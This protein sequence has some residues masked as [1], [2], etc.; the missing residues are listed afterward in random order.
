MQENELLAV[1]QSVLFFPQ[2]FCYS[3]IMNV[4]SSNRLGKEGGQPWKTGLSVV[5]HGVNL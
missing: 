3:K 5:S 2:L 4:I 1:N